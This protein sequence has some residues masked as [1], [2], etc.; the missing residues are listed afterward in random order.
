MTRKEEMEMLRSHFDTTD[1][2]RT[3]LAG[4]ALRDFYSRTADYWAEAVV[5]KWRT[6]QES[7]GKVG[8]LTNKL[9]SPSNSHLGGAFVGERNQA[10]GLSNGGGALS[11]APSSALSFE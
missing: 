1:T 7:E 2:H 5:Q 9:Y 10:I 11:R 6:D 8:I 4:E 3:P